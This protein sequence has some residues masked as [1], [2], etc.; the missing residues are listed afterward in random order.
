MRSRQGMRWLVVVGLMLAAGPVFAAGNANFLLGGRGLDEGEWEPVDQHSVFG[1]TVDFGGADWP[2]HMETGFY[3][4]GADDRAEDL[5]VGGVDVTVAVGEAFFGVNKTWGLSGN[6]RPFVGGGLASVVAAVEL[7]SVTFPLSEDDDDQSL[8][9]YV[10]GGV[11]WRLGP[12]FNIGVD[13][14]FL[15]GTDLTLFG[16]DTDVDYVQ[17]GLVLGFGWPAAK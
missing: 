16:E 17:L 8:G 7:D 14:R 6:V 11:F 9:A 2:V 12:R 15:G 3:G 13:G 4:S 10:H 5:F 1:V